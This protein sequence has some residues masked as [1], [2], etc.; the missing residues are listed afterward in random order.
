[1]SDIWNA[2]HIHSCQHTIPH[3]SKFIVIS[4]YDGGCLGFLINTKI[5][6]FIKNRP[7]LYHSQVLLKAR[8]YS[9]LTHDSF[10]DCSRLYP[11]DIDELFDGRGRLLESTIKII[12]KTVSDSTTLEPRYIDIIVN[13]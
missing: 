3:K 12:K 13:N 9:F 10:L 6:N 11:F 5:S 1:M 8:D 2:F 7:P 4:C